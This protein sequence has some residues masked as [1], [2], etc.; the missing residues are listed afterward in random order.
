[1]TLLLP[2]GFA[3]SLTVVAEFVLVFLVNTKTSEFKETL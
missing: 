3:L 2:T 1:M